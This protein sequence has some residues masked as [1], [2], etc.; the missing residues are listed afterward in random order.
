MMP[1]WDVRM[2]L[3]SNDL[4]QMTKTAAMPIHG[5]NLLQNNWVSCLGT[6]YVGSGT[7]LLHNLYK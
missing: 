5:K 4:G 7:L 6:R 1:V 3:Y 2:K